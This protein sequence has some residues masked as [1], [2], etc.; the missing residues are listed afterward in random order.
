MLLYG[1]FYDDS[2]CQDGCHK[3]AVFA[4]VVREKFTLST[5]F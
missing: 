3:P 4:I 5:L 2:S 1:V